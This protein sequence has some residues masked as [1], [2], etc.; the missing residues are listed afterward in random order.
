MKYSQGYAQLQRQLHAAGDYGVSGYKHSDRILQ[1]AKQI[2]TKD[3][4]DFGCGRQTLAKALPFA[5]TNYD[6]HID[7]LDAEPRVHDLVICSDVLEHIEPECLPDVLSHLISKVGKALFIDV[8]VRPAKKTLADG[9]NA[10]LIQ[11]PASWWLTQLLPSLEPMFIQT[12]AG[13]F[14]GVFTPK[15]VLA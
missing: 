4:L 12:Y 5:I 11:E 8:A 10:H 6:P 9:R 13:G 2:G 14:V 7:G 15:A 1:L 3:I